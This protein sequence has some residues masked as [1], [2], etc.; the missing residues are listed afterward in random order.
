MS[1]RIHVAYHEGYEEPLEVALEYADSV[2]APGATPVEGTQDGNSIK[3]SNGK[4]LIFDHVSVER[5][6]NGVGVLALYEWADEADSVVPAETTESDPDATW[7][8]DETLG[9]YP[10]P[11]FKSQPQPYD[12]SRLIN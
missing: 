8:I 2:V 4:Y 12:P 5:L 9:A 6:P 1:K 10:S 7:L 11:L 3:L